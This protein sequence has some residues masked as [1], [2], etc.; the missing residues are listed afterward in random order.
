MTNITQQRY[1]NRKTA[2]SFKDSPSM[3][4]QCHKDECKIQNIM[5]KYKK[6]GVLNHVSQYQGTYMDMATAPDYTEAQNI[7]AE[8]KSMFE[9]VPSHIRTQFNNDAS[10]YLD[11]MQNPENRKEIEALGLD[12]SHLPKAPVEPVTA[13]KETKA[14]EEAPAGKAPTEA[15]T[16]LQE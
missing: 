6:T 16:A 15:A 1:R 9:T 3:T 11:F 7:I 8:A 2:I 4:E 13:K 10:Q 12:A 5:R 14:P